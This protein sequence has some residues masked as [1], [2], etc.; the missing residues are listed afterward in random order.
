[1]FGWLKRKKKVL[2]YPMDTRRNFYNYVKDH[3]H[4]TE[5]QLV[6]QILFLSNK[7]EAKSVSI[8][9]LVRVTR[10][11]LKRSHENAEKMRAKTKA[12][13]PC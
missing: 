5:G 1:M 2:N 10:D 6:N 4:W 7:N 13:Q 3:S 8:L 12:I 9:D 11:E